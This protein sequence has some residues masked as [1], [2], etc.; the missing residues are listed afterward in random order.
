MFAGV[1]DD[2]R[3]WTVSVNLNKAKREMYSVQV[4]KESE[5]IQVIAEINLSGR[6]TVIR[7]QKLKRSF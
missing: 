1:G 3:A 4:L 7:K 2:A 5:L 6:G